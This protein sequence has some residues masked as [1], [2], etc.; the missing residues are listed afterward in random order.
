MGGPL[1]NKDKGGVCEADYTRGKE[2]G[3]K[4]RGGGGRRAGEP[5]RDNGLD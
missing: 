1:E 4:R 5:N 2:E 3:E